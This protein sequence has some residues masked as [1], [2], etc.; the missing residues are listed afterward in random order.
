MLRPAAVPALSLGLAAVLLAPAPARACG[1]TP[2]GPEPAPYRSGLV[3]VPRNVRVGLVSV[4]TRDPAVFSE[5]RLVPRGAPYDTP[6]LPTRVEA[7][8]PYAS[9]PLRAFLVP[10]A[11]LEAG[12]EYEVRAS[13]GVLAF[14][15]ARADEDVTAPAP[16]EGLAAQ[17]RMEQKTPNSCDGSEGRMGVLQL[18]VA[19]A[20]EPVTYTVHMDGQL[21]LADVDAGAPLVGHVQCTPGVPAGFPTGWV[22]RPGPHVFTV[23]AHDLAG[24]ASLLTELRLEVS[25]EDGVSP[26]RPWTEGDD[27]EEPWGCGAAGGLAPA[28]AA[29]G[30]L[31]LGPW[32]RRRAA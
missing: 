2:L 24:N 8:E 14:L 26:L 21:V 17:L 19:P 30:V 25:C 31:A 22:L 12:Q 13:S 9:G 18:S 16:A 28:L 32:R 20:P 7:R 4:G 23:T 1:P 6:G 15:R 27:V 10:L 3:D 5:A 29:L 11:P